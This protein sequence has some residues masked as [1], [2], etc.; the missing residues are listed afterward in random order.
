VLRIA[1]AARSCHPVLMWR[2]IVLLLLAEVLPAC[3][4][5]ALQ[6]PVPPAV[7]TTP[8]SP[9]IVGIPD[10]TA[11]PRTYTLVAS[12]SWLLNPPST[13]RFDASGLL[14]RK[15]GNLYTVND[16]SAGLYRIDHYNPGTAD[17]VR[18]PTWFTP[19]QLKA[20]KA[21]KIGTWDLEG[22]T[23][24]GAGHIYFCEEKNRW[25]LRADL[26]TGELVPLAIDWTPVRKWFSKD[27]NASWEGIA[28]G[29][30]GRLYLANERSIGRIVVVDLATNQV[31]DDFQVTPLGRHPHD[32]MYSDLCWFEGELWVLCRQ[33]RRVLRVDPPTHRVLSDFDYTEI[34]MSAEHGYL[35]PLPYGQFEGVSVDATDIWLVIDNNGS[36]RAIKRDDTRPT[37]FRC[38]R[39]DR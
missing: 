19:D 22:L 8:S 13:N 18:D 21:A 16:K 2:W 38:H 17:L 30:N 7:A 23:E 10:N 27:I 6:N 31:V 28:V 5:Q 15:D 32:V 12:E 29:D 35:T 9:R 1:T 36:P 24:D 20:L 4:T 39:P 11:H 3:R 14:R 26:Q 25:V 34:E 33:S 37:L